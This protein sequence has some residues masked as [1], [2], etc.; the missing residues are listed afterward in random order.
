MYKE[1]EKLNYFDSLLTKMETIY[2]FSICKKDEVKEVIAFLKTFWNPN[3]ILVK[4]RE[5]FDWQY[6]NEQTGSYNFVIARNKQ[7]KEIDC[8]HGFIPVSKYD[9]NNTTGYMWGAIW[10][11]RDDIRVFGLGIAIKCYMNRIF[12]MSK[13]LAFGMSGFSIDN[14]ASMGF[15]CG[16]A[17]HYFMLNPEKTEFYLCDGVLPYNDINYNGDDKFLF[18]EY[19]VKD[20]QKIDD[21]SIIFKAYNS[22][23]SKDF[24]INRFFKHPWY[25]YKAYAIK[26]DDVKAIVFTRECIVEKSKCLRI[27]DYVGIHDWLIPVNGKIKRLLKSNDYEYIDLI[28]AGENPVTMAMAGFINKKVD[29]KIIIPNY[30]EPFLKE[31]VNV[32]YARYKNSTSTIFYKADGDQDRPNIIMQRRCIC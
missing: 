2:N 1:I 28:I 22:F 6:F 20:F 32:Y 10:K 29:S 21:K 25:E 12:P 7:R 4:S 19:S 18:E 23:K 11:V 30:F 3:H 5:L 13:Y 15:E 27:V 16:E 9:K 8:V 17:E 31:N 14:H 26:K 24:Y